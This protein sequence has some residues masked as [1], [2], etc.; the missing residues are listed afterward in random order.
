MSN[1]ADQDD[2]CREAARAVIAGDKEKVLAAALKMISSPT[3]LM[4]V[5]EVLAGVSG[6]KKFSGTCSML[7]AFFGEQMLPPEIDNPVLPI[8]ELYQSEGRITTIDEVNKLAIRIRSDWDLAISSL[9]GESADNGLR[10]FLKS[11]VEAAQDRVRRVQAKWLAMIE[12][13]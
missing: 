2:H 7:A 10:V 5:F 6:N 11:R 12:E 3:R 8:K 4:L 1:E 9:V 13:Q